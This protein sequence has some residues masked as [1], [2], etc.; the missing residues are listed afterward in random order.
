MRKCM[1][2]G[3]P[4]PPPLSCPPPTAAKSLLGGGFDESPLGI[5]VAES[6]YEWGGAT[7]RVAWILSGT[8]A[9]RLLIEGWHK[10]VW[11]VVEDGARS[12]SVSLEQRLSMISAGRWIVERKQLFLLLLL[13]L[14][15]SIH[16]LNVVQ[17]YSLHCCRSRENSFSLSAGP[18]QLVAHHLDEVD[19]I[20]VGLEEKTV[21]MFVPELCKAGRPLLGALHVVGLENGL[22]SVDGRELVV[23]VP[24][25]FDSML[26]ILNDKPLRDYVK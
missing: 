26:A 4:P 6:E 25:L 11:V 1:A 3:S 5:V 10:K 7:V 12:E 18:C 17:I 14:A 16:S 9:A 19:Q 23:E 22:A 13:Y 15:K 21:Q 20:G 2:V 8:T 24:I